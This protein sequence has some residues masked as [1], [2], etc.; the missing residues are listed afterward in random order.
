MLFCSLNYIKIREGLQ[1][2]SVMAGFTIRRYED[3]DEESVK[4]VFIM[5]M[6]EHLPSS[7]MHLLK[8]PLTQMVLMV[9]FC[10]LMASS[11]SFLLPVVAVTLLL[12]GGKQLVGY[13]FN[14]Y[15]NTSLKMDLNNIR[16]TYLES[17][18]S[19]F[20]VAESDGQVVGTVACLPSVSDP[21]VME[22]K[23]LSVRRTHR[24]RGMAKALSRT[25]AGFSGE[26]GFSA[27]TL[28]TS[29]VQ[30]DAQKLYEHLGYKQIREFVIPELIAKIMNFTLIEY[31]LDLQPGKE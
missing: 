11:K 24:G 10:T 7:F 29:I 9:T 1:E 6:T 18:N 13:L 15:I 28:F 26:R 2:H 19:G 17:Q 8:Q 25:V 14:S 22:L 3:D 20:W 5:G 12:A 30:T 31:R 27:V 21:G 4:E 16:E 23:R